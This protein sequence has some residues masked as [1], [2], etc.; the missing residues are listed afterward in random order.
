LYLLTILLSISS[1]SKLTATTS[2]ILSAVSPH[3]PSYNT[4]SGEA[5]ASHCLNS[6]P[7]PCLLDSF[8]TASASA[9]DNYLTLLY[10]SL[11]TARL[12]FHHRCSHIKSLD[13]AIV[14]ILTGVSPV[15]QSHQG[16]SLNTSSL[17]RRG[18]STAVSSPKAI[19]FS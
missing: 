11:I 8:F 1:T 5:R 7:L 6:K 4:P 14:L 9:P 18:K 3:T 19:V 12:E 2:L 15:G 17:C 10:M 16:S 13:T